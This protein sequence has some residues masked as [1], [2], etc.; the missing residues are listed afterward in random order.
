MKKYVLILSSAI[1]LSINSYSQKNNELLQKAQ[2]LFNKFTPATTDS[3]FSIYQ[4]LIAAAPTNKFVVAGIA[5]VYAEK[6]RT[7]TDREQMRKWI[8]STNYYADKALKYDDKLLPALIAKASVL[9]RQGNP[10][11][12]ANLMQKLL[13]N[14]P[15]Y[16]RG[17]RLYAG[18]AR[19]AGNLQDHWKWSKKA[20]E[21]EPENPFAWW[22]YA[23][24]HSVTNFF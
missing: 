7:T 11:E 15:D 13:Q 14:D 24:S 16:P 10:E 4:Q 8:D 20:T 5:E 1:A 3:A 22:E 18:I 6:T 17:A 21:Q 12:A 23:L 19:S 2:L 9:N